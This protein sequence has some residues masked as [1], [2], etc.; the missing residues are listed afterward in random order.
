MEAV[1]A[2]PTTYILIPWSEDAHNPYQYRAWAEVVGLV[3]HENRRT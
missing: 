3:Q 2:Y 1:D